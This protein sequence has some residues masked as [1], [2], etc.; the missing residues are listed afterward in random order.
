MP[1]ICVD[2]VHVARGEAWKQLAQILA[3]RPNIESST[4]VVIVD[5]HFSENVQE[6][7]WMRL[8]RKSL[9]V[10]PPP[11]EPTTNSID[12][13]MKGLGEQI[14]EQ[15]PSVVV[16]I[17]GGSALDT[18]KAIANLLTN[19]GRAAD[20]QGWDLVTRA[21]IDSIG[22][23]TIPGTGAEASRT[24]VLI[25]SDTGVKLGMNSNFSVFDEVI[26]DSDLSLTVPRET[27]FFTA[28]DSYF[29]AVELLGG[30]ARN[31]ISD[32]LAR[33]ARQYA[34]DAFTEGDMQSSAAREKLLKASFLAGTAIAN[35]M[36]GLVH[37]MSA[38]LSSV[39]GLGHGLANCIVMRAMSELME[40]EYNEFRLFMR[41]Q[42]IT[43]PN[44]SRELSDKNSV[45]ELVKATLVHRRP[46]ENA[47]GPDFD[48]RLTHSR[49]A[50]LFTAM[51]TD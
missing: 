24:C 14:S 35:G 20:Y 11:G 31:L 21:G 49:L 44:L 8:P 7:E 32:A 42:Q 22:V 38:A 3:G 41:T 19:S 48:R 23:P 9:A 4:M 46:L 33:E 43:L 36:V 10:V 28:M 1:F 29:H 15:I 16:G 27:Y 47:L 25:N 51:G 34:Y 2:Q 45:D 50:S 5:Q 17:G 18:A 40:T 6:S 12:D 37:P 26:L 13:L 39:L 30:A